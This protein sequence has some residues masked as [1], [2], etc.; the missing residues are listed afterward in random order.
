MPLEKYR[1][2]TVLGDADDG[3]PVD[4]RLKLEE[5]GINEP[6]DEAGATFSDFEPAALGGRRQHLNS[7]AG[8]SCG[9]DFLFLA[10]VPVLAHGANVR[11]IEARFNRVG[12]SAS[13]G[14]VRYKHVNRTTLGSGYLATLKSALVQW[15]GSYRLGCAKWRKAT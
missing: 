8:Q 13:A 10:E 6:L 12:P 3:T 11:I 2:K 9:C 14:R 7:V 1:T 15:P 4:T 5:V